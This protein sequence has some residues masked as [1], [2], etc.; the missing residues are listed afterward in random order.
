MQKLYDEVLSLDKRCYEEFYLS[1][2]L[3]MEHAADAMADFIRAR[4]AKGSSVIVVCGGGNNGA[5]GIACARMLHG[6]YDV[7]IYYAKE[8]KSK[9]AK[10]QASRASAIGV[11]VLDELYDAD[12]LVDALFGTG[13]NGELDTKL[14]IFMDIMNDSH[15]FKIACDVPSGYKFYADTTL[16]MGALKKDMYL[17]A[18]KEYVGDIKVLDLGVSREVYETDSNWN[19]LDLE[20]L[21]LPNRDKKDTHKGSFGHLSCIGGEKIGAGVLCAKSALRFG[22]GLVTIAGYNT[23]NIPHSIMSSEL[24]PRTTTA[25]AIGMGLGDS[26]SDRDLKSFLDND[27]PL[28]ADADLF[29]MP[30]ILDILKRENIVLTPHPKEFVSLLKLCNL[31]DISVS[32]LQKNRFKYVELFCKNYPHVTLLLKG[33]NVIVGQKNKFYVNPHGG[34]K[35]AKGGSGDVLSGLV[36]SLLAQGYTPL[37]AACNASLA[38]TKLALNYSGSDF[39]LTPDD[40]ISGI[41]KL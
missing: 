37:E 24:L 2:D 10:L 9:L 20:D 12:V 14:T 27:Y 16:T 32:E 25:M 28:I 8:P 15:G 41:C 11:K 23:T 6:D 4:F 34:S 40:L 3:L 17:D 13:F 19:L 18:H 7:G 33:A 5:D 1:E 31:A 22:V 29:N 39:S 36:G 38:H 35:L 21:K 26:Y 30:T